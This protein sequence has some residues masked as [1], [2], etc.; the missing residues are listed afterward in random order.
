ML[1][2]TKKYEFSVKIKNKPLIEYET[3]GDTFI[4]GRKGVFVQLCITVHLFYSPALLLLI[5]THG[6]AGQYARKQ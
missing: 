4:E 1:N 2:N 6:K 3:N 5:G